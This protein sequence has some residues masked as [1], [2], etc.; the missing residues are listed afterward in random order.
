MKSVV[1]IAEA[2]VNHNGDINL[3]KEL[4]KQAKHVK[5]DY[6]KFQSFV[7]EENI[8]SKAPKTEYQLQTTISSESQFQMLK[9]F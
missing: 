8:S 7:T 4:I 3:A 1:I 6:V 5:A 9:K 2:G